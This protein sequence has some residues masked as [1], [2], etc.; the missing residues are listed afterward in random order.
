[1]INLLSTEENLQH[2]MNNTILFYEF[3]T[4]NPK[5]RDSNFSFIQSIKLNVKLKKEFLLL[6]QYTYNSLIR[7]RKAEENLESGSK[8]GLKYYRKKFNLK[9]Y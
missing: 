2:K 3:K 5:N 6:F 9:I 4:F 8:S 1:M 7:T